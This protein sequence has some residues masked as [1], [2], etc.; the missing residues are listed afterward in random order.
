MVYAILVADSPKVP[1]S[2]DDIDRILARD[3][4]PSDQDV[5][6]ARVRTVGLREYHFSIPRGMYR[7]FDDSTAPYLIICQTQGTKTGFSMM[8]TARGHP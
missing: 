8:S 6:K 2:V 3:Y 4:E 1:S 5:V 7:T